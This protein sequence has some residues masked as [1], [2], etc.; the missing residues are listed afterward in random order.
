MFFREKKSGGHS[1]LQIVRNRRVEGKSVQEVV[2]SLGRLDVLKESGEFEALMSSGA[3][4]CEKVSVL[5][6]Y[7]DSTVPLRDQKV[8]GSPLIFERL[9][10]ETG[11]QTAIQSMTA[12]R[13]FGFDLERALFVTVLHR[14]MES[15][16]DLQCDTWRMRYAISGAG[17]L[18]YH[19]LYRAMAFLGEPTA[20]WN[21]DDPL[22]SRYVFQHLEERIF[23]GNR[24]LFT[25]LEMVF[26]DTTS[27]Y[28]EGTGGEHLGERGHSKDHR[29][30]EHQMIVG[31]VIDESG[32]PICSE[33]WPGST[34]DVTTLIPVA[35]RLKRRFEIQS[36]C[37]VCDRGMISEKV[38]EELENQGIR[39]I[40][41]ARMR[42]NREV[43]NKVL[44]RGGRY[45]TILPEREHVKDR[46]PL[47]VKNVQVGD[48]RYV[49]CRN[50]EEARSD[51]VSRDAIVA[52]LK[53]QLKRGSVHLVGNKGYRQY[54]RSR[55]KGFEIDERKV[56]ED[57]RF[58]GKYV[59]RTNLD[60]PASEVA[61]KYKELWRVERVM[62]SIKSLFDTRPVYHKYDATIRGHVFC[63]F[64]ALKLIKELETRVTE[65]GFEFRWNDIK[66]SL[67]GIMEGTI[68]VGSKDFR[69]RSVIDETSSKVFRATGVKIPQFI[70]HENQ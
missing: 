56:C 43:R 49:I 41:G 19:H 22:S 64:L 70:V 30:D 53:S 35:E 13:R 36:M 5:Q 39:Y 4:F 20:D 55:G 32:N 65:H 14:L 10:K 26:F 60:R 15:G 42:R 21:E 59:L 37:V 33:M 54:L 69:V 31:I 7:D 2:A 24:D 12:D 9:W 23:L 68:T 25:R 61:R 8:V 16:S 17:S 11:I 47:D 62:R 28:F 29:P 58:D 34:A 52:S 57:A 27:I 44:S 38:I 46:A 45:Q 6:A 1:Y 3:K 40:I 48:H 51:A 66:R 18:A 50:P 67:D 63:S